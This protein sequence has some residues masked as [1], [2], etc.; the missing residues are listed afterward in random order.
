MP[1]GAWEAIELILNRG[2]CSSRRRETGSRLFEAVALLMLF[3]MPWKY[4]KG[5][6]DIFDLT[7]GIECEVFNN[8]CGEK[9]HGYNR[10]ASVEI[11]VRS[12][13]ILFYRR[14]SEPANTC[15][16]TVLRPSIE[17]RPNIFSRN[18]GDEPILDPVGIRCEGD[19]LRVM[20][21]EGLDVERCSA[22][23]A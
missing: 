13:A 23:H 15:Q 6:F 3:C 2:L 4:C 11:V 18:T 20:G 12:E 19:V 8:M 1:E 22:D 7:T 5:G 16:D 9:L 21:D 17:L 10:P 14:P